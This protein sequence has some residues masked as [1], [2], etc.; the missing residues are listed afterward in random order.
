M[1]IVKIILIALVALIAVLAGIGFMLPSG[2]KVER[3]VTVS[4]PPEIVFEQVNNLK[5]NEAWSPWMKND[6]TIKTTY[7]GP[8][9]GVGAKSSW[10]SEHSGNGSQ[11]IEESVPNQSITTFL[12]FGEM[13]NAKGIWTF[14]QEGE[15]T[16]VTEAMVGDSGKNPF[17]HLMN[18]ALDKMIGK[19]FEQGLASLKTVAEKQA[20]DAK[21]AQAAQAATQQA[22]AAPAEEPAAAANAAPAKKP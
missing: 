13:G 16:K 6:P 4:A 15:G 22:A 17:K 11:T 8:E 20:A 12:D 19:Y 3:S 14:S 9:A 21:A 5:K 18:L 10:T 1:R 2:Y 7:S